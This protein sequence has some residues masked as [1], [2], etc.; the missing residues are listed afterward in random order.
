M[1]ISY[2]KSKINSIDGL[3]GA[4]EMYALSI[5]HKELSIIHL[6]KILSS[7]KSHKNALSACGI[8][9]EAKRRLKALKSTTRSEEPF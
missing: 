2:P 1:I 5:I 4:E 6:L 7:H 3:S 9:S 8:C